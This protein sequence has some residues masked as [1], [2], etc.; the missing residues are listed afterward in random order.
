M[1]GDSE[2][3]EMIAAAKARYGLGAAEIAKLAGPEIE[4][5]L[6]K[7]A[8]AGTDP[9]GRAWTAKKDGGRPLVNAASAISVSV[10]GPVIRGVL[11]GP[12]VFHHYGTGNVPRRRV[13]PDAGAG[14]PPGVAKVLL[15]VAGRSFD[16]ALHG[17]AA[18]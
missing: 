9:E 12:T 8:A 10:A 6:R 4:I 18:R 16:K 13:L 3:R 2:I 14:I 1:S 17:G 7:T 5:A 15:D 11:T